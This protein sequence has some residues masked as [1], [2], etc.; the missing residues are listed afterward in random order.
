MAKRVNVQYIQQLVQKKLGRGN[1][2]VISIWFI[3]SYSHLI[4]FLAVCKDL[5]VLSAKDIDATIPVEFAARQRRQI[6]NKQLK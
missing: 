6:I 4:R 1:W 2:F 5:S 3:Y